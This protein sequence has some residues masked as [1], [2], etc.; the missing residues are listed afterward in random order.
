[1]YD[2][3][4]HIAMAA[5]YIISCYNQPRHNATPLYY[6]KAAIYQQWAPNKY[7]LQEITPV[8]ITET[9]RPRVAFRNTVMRSKI[10]DLPIMGVGVESELSMAYF[11]SLA[12]PPLNFMDGLN[13]VYLLYYNK[14]LAERS[15]YHDFLSRLIAA[16]T[17][18]Y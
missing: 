4:S 10:I 15:E 17:D 1:M 9:H 14:I 18:Q 16:G 5:L 6:G 2:V 7:H 13:L 11:R 3:C 12:K 8:Q